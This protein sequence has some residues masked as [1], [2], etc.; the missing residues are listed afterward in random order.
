MTFTVTFRNNKT[1]K[2]MVNYFPNY[3]TGYR[4]LS[5]LAYAI[6]YEVHSIHG[7]MLVTAGSKTADFFITMERTS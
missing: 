1:G 3:S 7:D 5:N 4:A 2:K 6:G